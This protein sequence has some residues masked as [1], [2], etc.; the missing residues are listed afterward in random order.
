MAA[1]TGFKQACPSCEKMVPIK[2]PKLVGKKIECP[3]CKYR[4]TVEAPEEESDAD[5]VEDDTVEEVKTKPKTEAAKGKPTAAVAAAQNKATGPRRRRGEDDDDDDEDKP[6][7]KP[8]AKTGGPNVLVLGIGLAVVAVALLGVGGYYM[9]SPSA[10]PTKIVK[11][12]RGTGIKN[13]GDKDKVAEAPVVAAAGADITNLLPNNTELVMNCN[14]KELRSNPFGRAFET[15]GAFRRETLAE[16]LGLQLVEVERLVVAR[17]TKEDWWFAVVHT[18]KPY[19]EKTVIEKL[20]LQKQ[21][22]GPLQDAYTA[23]VGDWLTNVSRM[24]DGTS[25]AAPGDADK[26][27]L[28]AVRFIDSQTIVFSD[29]P[30]MEQFIKAKGRFDIKTAKPGERANNE[31]APGPGYMTINPAMKQLLERME[32]RS[33]TYLS[34]AVDT[35]IPQQRDRFKGWFDPLNIQA[36]DDLLA[37]GMTYQNQDQDTDN[38]TF[39][40]ECKKQDYAQALPGKLQE[41]FKELAKE[42]LQARLEI[43]QEFEEPMGKPVFPDA[44]RAISFYKQEFRTVTLGVHLSPQ[45]RK[46]RF[47][48]EIL[49]PVMLRLRGLLDMASGQ[50]HIHDL[51]DAL[52]Q[53]LADPANKKTFPRGAYP[54]KPVVARAGRP[55]PADN[56]ISWMVA[57]LPYLGPEYKLVAGKINLQSSWRDPSTLNQQLGATLVP[58]FLDPRSP[59]SSWWVTLPSLPFYELAT[60]Q[61]VGVAGIGL[62]AAEYSAT[63]KLTL[64]QLGIFGYDRDTTLAALTGG[65]ANTIAILQVPPTYKR[66][67]ISGGGST[68]QGVLEKDSI[69]PFVCTEH[70]GKKGTWAIMCDGAIRFIPADIADNVFKPM[71][72][73]AGGDPK[74]VEALPLLPARKTELKAQPVA[75]K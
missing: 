8:K 73:L 15:A 62:D 32:G 41:R 38:I 59:R 47:L 17:S 25:A 36:E 42:L 74:Q 21:S 39:G 66:P 69:K 31:P 19:D 40:V 9:L 64:N 35:A 44:P 26:K 14:I 71:C 55:W 10:P 61:F 37:F 53:Y 60:T 4:F 20:G 6:K 29:V 28:L 43:R 23:D 63:D 57:I 18:S 11:T 75:E 13:E 67:W 49:R 45:A 65:P 54:L 27:R 70:E 5:I 1:S 12:H 72:T 34:M 46:D 30:I 50:S 51:A 7:P 58:A 3:N 33:K 16:Q 24:F 52:R 48:T 56:R 68:V 2:D 22:R